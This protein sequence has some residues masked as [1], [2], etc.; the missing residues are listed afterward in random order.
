MADPTPGETIPTCYVYKTVSVATLLPPVAVNM[1]NQSGYADL[2]FVYGLQSEAGAPATIGGDAASATLQYSGP[3]GE[4]E[5]LQIA[6]VTATGSNGFQFNDPSGTSWTV[7]TQAVTG[8]TAADPILTAAI[9]MELFSDPALAFA[10]ETLKTELDSLS[11]GN[12]V[13]FPVDPIMPCFARGTLIRT[14]DGEVPVEDLAEGDRVAL[15]GGGE[16]AVRWIGRRRVHV[17]RHV[18]PVSVSPVRFEAGSLAEGVPS[19]A[20]RVSPDHAMLVSDV[21]VPAGLLVNGETIVRQDVETVEYFHVELPTHDVLIA[22]GAAAESY[23]DSGNRS[24]F[25]NASI[26]SL[27][28]RFAAERTGTPCREMGLS[29]ERLDAIR[30]SLPGRPAVRRAS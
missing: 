26:V 1:I 23:F 19:R 18:D 8:E 7:L 22:E 20:L 29:G 2:D 11:G 28:P 25:A 12:P 13:V 27:T 5:T 17:G 15:A 10:L 30:A 21:L 3:S 6:D 9:N 24:T 14:P 4:P 16:A